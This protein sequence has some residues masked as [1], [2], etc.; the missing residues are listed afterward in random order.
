M[1]SLSS[2]LLQEHRLVLRCAAPAAARWDSRGGWPVPA[3]EGGRDELQA[4]CGVPEHPLQLHL[5]NYTPAITPPAS[6][7]AISICKQE[8]QPGCSGSPRT[9]ITQLGHSGA[10]TQSPPWGTL[11][12]PLLSPHSPSSRRMQRASASSTAPAGWLGMAAGLAGMG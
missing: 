11:L 1:H 10:A 12:P 2:Q 4:R 5:C 9:C 8:I 6:I 7:R 3:A